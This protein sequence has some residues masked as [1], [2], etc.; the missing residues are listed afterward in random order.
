M[1][2]INE[3]VGTK[4]TLAPTFVS[5][6][7]GQSSAISKS[8][9]GFDDYANEVVPGFIKSLKEASTIEDVSRILGI[10]QAALEC[11]AAMLAPSFQLE[12]LPEN[13]RKLILGMLQNRNRDAEKVKPTMK[14]FG[15]EAKTG[16]LGAIE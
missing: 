7:A 10:P 2:I 6:A 1:D 3:I 15:M 9:G 5:S 12:N 4:V 13:L 14:L 11:F 8:E 16:V